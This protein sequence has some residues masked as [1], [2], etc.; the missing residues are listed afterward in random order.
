MVLGPDLMWRV[1]TTSPPLLLT[2][3]FISPIAY[4]GTM[5]E[6]KYEKK[7]KPCAVISSYSSTGS[8]GTGKGEAS[9]GRRWRLEWHQHHPV[10][11]EQRRHEEWRRMNTLSSRISHRPHVI[12]YNLTTSISFNQ[13]LLL[14]QV[15]D[16][17]GNYFGVVSQNN[18][19][20][21]QSIITITSAIS[22]MQWL[23]W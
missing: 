8:V 23:I 1:N 11:Q 5:E 18:N 17:K 13:N 21:I 4:R 10:P 7:Q 12:Y 14:Y 22:I 20:T 16:V 15:Q 3:S 2:H 6:D 19:S 9:L